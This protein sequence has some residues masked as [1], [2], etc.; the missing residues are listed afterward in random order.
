MVNRL[1]RRARRGWTMIEMSIVLAVIVIL[2]AIAA[3]N[4]DFAKFRMDG[5]MRALQNQLIANQLQSVQRQMP[6]IVT[7][8]YD[9]GHLTITEDKNANG[10]ADPEEY[11]YNRTLAEGAQFIIPPVTIDSA[12]AYYATGPGLTY[13]N[14][15]YMY[16]TV[17]FYPNGSTSGNVVVYIG[18]SSGRLTDMRALAITGSTSKVRFYRMASDGT[19]RAAEM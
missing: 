15:T 12:T 19:W 16:P 11:T 10:V 5:N 3:P 6:I 7:V 1:T 9:Q 13:L 8:V 4:I 2:L 18:S 17:T 14:Q